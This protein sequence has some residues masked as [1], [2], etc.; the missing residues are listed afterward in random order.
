MHADKTQLTRPEDQDPGGKRALSQTEGQNQTPWEDQ[1]KAFVEQHAASVHCTHADSPDDYA[2]MRGWELTEH[3]LVR[4]LHSTRR[5]AHPRA[6]SRR[7]ALRDRP[8]NR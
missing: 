6:Q 7:Q 5:P 8:G 3:A 1:W 4:A 2:R